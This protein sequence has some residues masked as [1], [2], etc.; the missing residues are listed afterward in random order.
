MPEPQ[1]SPDRQPPRKATCPG[2]CRS[3]HGTDLG[4]ENW[5]HVSEPLVLDDGLVARLCMSM[6]P[7]SGAKDGPYVLI[8]STEY[9]LAEAEALGASLVALAGTVEP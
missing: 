7:V 4:E 8:G 6:D 3:W 5:L 1:S 9:T 2:W